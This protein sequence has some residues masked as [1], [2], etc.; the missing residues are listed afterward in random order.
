MR[1]LKRRNQWDKLFDGFTEMKAITFVSQPEFL[2]IISSRGYS[3][4]EL[5]VGKD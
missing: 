1:T 3:K 5:L 4:I 2:L